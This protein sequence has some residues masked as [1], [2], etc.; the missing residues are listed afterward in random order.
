MYDMAL[1][2]DIE[3]VQQVQRCPRDTNDLTHSRNNIVIFLMNLLYVH[4]RTAQRRWRILGIVG[5]MLALLCSSAMTT[6]LPLSKTKVLQSLRPHSSQT[7]NELA[8]EE[9][10]P[11]PEKLMTVFIPTTLVTLLE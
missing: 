3:S 2:V 9:S 7:I 10:A 8:S 5:T 1:E 11:K 4:M 6:T